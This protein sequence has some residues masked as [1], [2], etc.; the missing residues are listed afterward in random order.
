[1]PYEKIN[2]DKDFPGEEQKRMIKEALFEYTHSKVFPSVFAGGEYLGTLSDLEDA[3]K[4]G[5]LKKVLSK[6]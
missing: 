6:N 1:M 5:E 4:S 2:V 3:I